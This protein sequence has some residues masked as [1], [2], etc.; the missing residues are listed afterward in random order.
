MRTLDGHTFV[1]NMPSDAL[2]AQLIIEV[3]RALE[4]TLPPDRVEQPRTV[5]NADTQ[6]T[7]QY[8]L[9]AA[10][11]ADLRIG[12]FYGAPVD[13]WSERRQRWLTFPVCF[14]LTL[15]AVWDACMAPW[16]PLRA[17]ADDERVLEVRRSLAP[18]SPFTSVDRNAYPRHAVLD[19]TDPRARALLRKAPHLVDGPAR[20]VSAEVAVVDRFRLIHSGRQMTYDRTLR[21]HGIVDGDIIHIVPRTRGS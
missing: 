15:A 16:A 4:Y 9:S 10:G 6:E 17:H 1:L 13:A 18:D 3:A 12:D 14:D 2:L 5:R 20:V 19:W 8:F 11:T 21:E 7:T